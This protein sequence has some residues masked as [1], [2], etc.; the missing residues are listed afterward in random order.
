MAFASLK[1][2]PAALEA[3]LQC[4]RHPPVRATT[5][6]PG[7]H[8]NVP[9]KQVSQCAGLRLLAPT[10]THFI[11][12][13]RQ[14]TLAHACSGLC[15]PASGLTLISTAPG[16]LCG[17]A[18][19]DR[20]VVR[21]QDAY[22][23]PERLGIK[24]RSYSS[25]FFPYPIHSTARPR[26]VVRAAAEQPFLPKDVMRTLIHHLRRTLAAFLGRLGRRE[27]GTHICCPARRPLDFARK[28]SGL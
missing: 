5:P 2:C 13:L 28:A 24:V 26:C 8:S 9:K 27:H 20:R 1:L 7:H 14:S 4:P 12:P 21:D 19:Q 15:S 3:H 23:G 25:W 18:G 10:T 22:A 16:I 11:Y 6:G 17:G